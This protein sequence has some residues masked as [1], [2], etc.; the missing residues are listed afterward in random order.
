MG[1]EHTSHIKPPATDEERDRHR[2]YAQSAQSTNANIAALTRVFGVL[3]TIEESLERQEKF[4]TKMTTIAS[5][6]GVLWVGV[7]G[8][9]GF[10]ASR[11][12]EGNDQMSARIEKLEKTAEIYAIIFK[13]HENV[14]DQVQA[15][16]SRL[17]QLEDQVV[18]LQR[19]ERK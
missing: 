3:Q 12:V 11:V 19:R 13:P 15:I 4:Q 16:K 1:D 6:V 5:V 14:P 17:N 7:S 8:I 18:D 9:V 2:F 10:Y